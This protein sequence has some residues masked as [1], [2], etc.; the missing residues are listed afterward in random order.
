MVQALAGINKRLIA[1]ELLFCK[2]LKDYKKVE[3]YLNT[4]ESK[5]ALATTVSKLKDD[6]AGALA[7]ISAISSTLD[8]LTSEGGNDD[9]LQAV[10]GK[11]KPVNDKLDLLAAESLSLHNALV[12][13]SSTLS[14]EDIEREFAELLPA[15]PQSVQA[16]LTA[17]KNLLLELVALKTN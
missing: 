12:R 15:A 4:F 9:V 2:H 5:S 6:M 16:V 17:I 10:D 14:V 1:S 13:M 7:S 3:Y 8:K 11:L